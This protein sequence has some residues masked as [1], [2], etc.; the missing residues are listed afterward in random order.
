MIFNIG[1]G[2]LR[3]VLKVI[4]LF[5]LL[6]AVPAELQQRDTDPAA[7]WIGAAHG[8]SPITVKEGDRP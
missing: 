3:R 7:P 4:R 6:Q 2:R 5:R 8:A 1:G